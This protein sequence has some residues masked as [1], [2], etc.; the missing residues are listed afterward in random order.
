MKTKKCLQWGPDLQEADVAGR[1]LRG[2]RVSSLGSPGHCVGGT[3]DRAVSVGLLTT[4]AEGEAPKE[5]VVSNT[6]TP[7]A[8]VGIELYYRTEEAPRWLRTA[9]SD[10]ASPNCWS[11]T[12]ISQGTTT[13]VPSGGSSGSIPSST[14]AA[15]SSQSGP[16]APPPVDEENFPP[17]SSIFARQQT[18]A[19]PPDHTHTPLSTFSLPS[20][21]LRLATIPAGCDRAA[22]APFGSAF[23]YPEPLFP[24]ARAEPERCGAVI[25]SFCE[26]ASSVRLVAEASV[27]PSPL[28]VGSWALSKGPLL[29]RLPRDTQRLILSFMPPAVERIEVH[30]TAPSVQVCTARADQASE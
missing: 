24:C 5:Y 17:L 12:D 8:G 29:Q 11:N 28:V 14:P 18:A 10:A 26:D 20:P 1:L 13:N 2:I 16:P 3:T 4:D 30:F 25:T 22:L 21:A 7:L 15:C 19:S 23:Q 6:G 27:K 9:C